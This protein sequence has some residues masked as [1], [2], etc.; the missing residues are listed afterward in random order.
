MSAVIKF[1][2]AS[3]P[4]QQPVSRGCNVDDNRRSGYV[5]LFK[6]MKDSPFYKDPSRKA[7]WIHLLIEAVH[8]LTESTFNGN[9]L[10]L[11]RGQVVGSARYLG[12]AC[13]VSED[14]ARRSLDAFEREGMITRISKQGT[15][16]YTLITILNYDPYQ[17]GV[18]EHIGAELPAE[19]EPASDKGLEVVSQSDGAELSAE[20]HA[21]DLNN[22]NNKTST[23]LKDYCSVSGETK[24]RE[25]VQVSPDALA[26]LTH[27]NTTNNRRYRPS[28]ASL[29]HIN[30]RLGEG[31]T[32]AELQLV[33]DYK[34]EHWG[35]NLKMAEFLR[36]ATLFAPQ[37][38]EG[39][40][41]SAHR[42]HEL[43]R[44]SYAN[45][46]WGGHG[47]KRTLGNLVAA[48]QAAQQ[49]I[50]SGAV[51]YDDDTPL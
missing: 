26:V 20:F 28:K 21:E 46:E 40:L 2:G 6:S 36:P 1:P 32:V 35:G 39:Y 43:G 48:Q 22:I 17:R 19:L 13:G 38:F 9:R 51:S 3:A 47:S 11:T 31:G 27:L 44:P 41:A 4:I 14:S 50:A 8:E 12:E 7:L 16:G 5:L 45:G 25:K 15:K 30:A 49:L 42:W 24:R 18:S 34:T 37:K 33:I 23:D 29:Q 10:T